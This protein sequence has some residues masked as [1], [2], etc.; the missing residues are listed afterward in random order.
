[1]A[2]K[3]YV[4]KL[5]DWIDELN[6]KK[7]D[8]D[9]LSASIVSENRNIK[10][11]VSSLQSKI[12][13]LESENRSTLSKLDKAERD[14]NSSSQT[15]ATLTNQKKNL[16]NELKS[17]RELYVSRM[18]ADKL[19]QAELETLRAEQKKNAAALQTYINRNAELSAMLDTKDSA[20]RTYSQKIDA[21][22]KEIDDKNA[23]IKK[24]DDIISNTDT[25]TPA[26]KIATLRENLEKAERENSDFR[27]NIDKLTNE[28]NS[29][30][31]QLRSAKNELAIFRTPVANS[32]VK[33]G[34]NSSSSVNNSDYQKLLA[35]FNDLKNKYDFLSAEVESLNK[36]L[37]DVDDK[38]PEI[39]SDKELANFL[40]KAAADAANANDYISAAWYFS[41]LAKQAPKNDLYTFGFALYSSVASERAAAAKN[42]SNLKNSR[43][44]Y[45]LEGVLAMLDGKKSSAA[46]SF[47]KA[48][49]YE[50]LSTDI[51]NLYARDL[52]LIMN[53][54]NKKGEM[55]ETL[56]T[57]QSL[58]K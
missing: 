33:A 23:K 7:G 9:K 54:F 44:K 16:E 56:H 25:A 6:K 5:N 18:N 19:T 1:M 26:K 10:N 24:L 13:Q 42:I 55:A 20:S 51:K 48:K 37:A 35:A 27:R 53:L 11:E 8:S 45:I 31:A 17:A 52:P 4:K 43:E 12:R 41:E 50:F 30:A 39:S 40:L 2:D 46:D 32:S 22:Q 38:S 47:K 49:K 28:N 57:L 34:D 58:L 21:L 14:F 15:I 3:A 36:P 29:L